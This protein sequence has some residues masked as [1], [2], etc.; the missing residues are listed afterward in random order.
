[1]VVSTGSHDI[2]AVMRVP[3]IE[4]D[5]PDCRTMRVEVRQLVKLGPGVALLEVA[6]DKQVSCL[7]TNYEG[8]GTL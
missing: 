8:I 5:T 4:L 3:L 1:M 2:V 7:E 6:P